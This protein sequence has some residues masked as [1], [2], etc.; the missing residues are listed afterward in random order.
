MCNKTFEATARAEGQ[1][2][3]TTECEVKK[4]PRSVK[5]G[6]NDRASSEEGTKGL[7][8]EI[9]TQSIPDDTTHFHTPPRGGIIY[10]HPVP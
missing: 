5:R 1:E 10:V 8:S 4:E 9:P 6:R 3:G 7:N 2:E